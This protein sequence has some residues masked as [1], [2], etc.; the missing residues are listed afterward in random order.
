MAWNG[1]LPSKTVDLGLM[2][3]TDNI[4][5]TGSAA[6]LYQVTVYTGLALL[7]AYSFTCF[8][9]LKM[10]T[11]IYTALQTHRSLLAKPRHLGHCR[12]D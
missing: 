7:L 8:P 5:D 10:A 11:A 4:V 3:L 9:F 12:L 1:T 6:S 2:F